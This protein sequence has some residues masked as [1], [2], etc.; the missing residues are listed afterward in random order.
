MYHILSL[1]LCEYWDNINRLHKRSTERL[2]SSIQNINAMG[3]HNFSVQ[4]LHTYLPILAGCVKVHQKR[5]P[6]ANL[7][8]N[9]QHCNQPPEVADVN[10]DNLCLHT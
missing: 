7:S 9:M 6:H 8:I 2:S 3:I 4:S 10:F 5:A 1:S